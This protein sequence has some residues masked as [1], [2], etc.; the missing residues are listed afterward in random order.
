M[1]DVGL[2]RIA[3]TPGLALMRMT[4]NTWARP[5]MNASE[6]PG[7]HDEDDCQ[8]L[9]CKHLP[10]A[11]GLPLSVDLEVFVKSDKALQEKV[12]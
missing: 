9:H 3:A 2:M 4:V 6:R 5:N 12:K 8:H 11:S 7:L 10:H 1:S